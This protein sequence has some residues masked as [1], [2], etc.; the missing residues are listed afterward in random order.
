MLKQISNRS[1]G[2]RAVGLELRG[3]VV[4]QWLMVEVAVVLENLMLSVLH[5]EVATTICGCEA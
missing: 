2:S 5:L 1:K 3:W 4:V